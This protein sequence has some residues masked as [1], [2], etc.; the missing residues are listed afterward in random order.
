[1]PDSMVCTRQPASAAGHHHMGSAMETSLC[2]KAIPAPAAQLG[3]TGFSQLLGAAAAPWHLVPK[4]GTGRSRVQTRC[5]ARM[6]PWRLRS[7]GSA[8]HIIV[9]KRSG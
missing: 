1:M 7:S 2:L 4:G 3:H 6:K 5:R 9:Y 8:G